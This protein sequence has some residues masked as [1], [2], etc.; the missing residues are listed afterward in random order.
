VDSGKHLKG[1]YFALYAVWANKVAAVNVEA[2]HKGL[3][4]MSSCAAG[5]ATAG[6]GLRLA[7][8]IGGHPRWEEG[9]R[10][11]GV[12]RGPHLQGQ[13]AGGQ[14]AGLCGAGEPVGES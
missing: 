2:K 11:W 3:R 12:L 5:A 13:W 14:L 7:L 8:A 1:R 10:D 6:D 9:G 4:H